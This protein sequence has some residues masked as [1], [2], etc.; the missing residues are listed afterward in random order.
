MLRE[1]VN[2]LVC[3]VVF[4]DAKQHNHIIHFQDLFLQFTTFHFKKFW[5]TFTYKERAL[6]FNNYYLDED[7]QRQA[8]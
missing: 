6:A 1:A 4:R 3:N 8:I 2:F 5:M 7:F